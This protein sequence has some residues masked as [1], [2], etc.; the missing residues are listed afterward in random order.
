MSPKTNV[1]K[2]GVLEGVKVVH[3]TQSAAGPFAAALM[4]DWGAEVVWVENPGAVD[5]TRWMKYL[6]EQD[7]RNQRSISLDIPSPEGRKVF[8]RLIKD[9]DIFIES[10][11]GGQYERWGLTDEVLWEQNPALVIAHISGFG[12]SGDK[13]YVKRPSFDPIAQAFSGHMMLNGYPDRPPI[14][15]H[16]VTA[17]YNTALITVSSSLAALTKARRTG[18]GESVDIAQYECMVR[19]HGGLSGEYFDKGTKP[20]REGNHSNLLAGWGS[21]TCKDGNEVYMLLAGAGILKAVIPE[22]GLEY[23][24]E[25]FPNGCGQAF[26]NTPEGLLLEEK[27]RDYCAS[28]TAQEVENRFAEIGAPCSLIMDIENMADH[29]HYIARETFTEW[30]TIGNKKFKGVNIVPRFKNNPGNIWRGCPS[31]GFDNEDILSELGFSA[32]EI[33][34]LYEKKIIMKK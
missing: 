8:F 2:F 3:A 32:E 19:C 23:G 21:Y 28:K 22:L 30:T 29:P 25:L 15:S 33:G 10:S 12:Q 27:I 31:T 13:N 4:A 34:M 9:A 18:K 16:P 24:S 11:K 1:P 5:V 20:K 17:D 6:M 7:R 14:P 26:F